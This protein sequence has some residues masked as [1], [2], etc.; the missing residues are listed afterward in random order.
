MHTPV[1]DRLSP[2]KSSPRIE[3]EEAS[4]DSD[5]LEDFIG[6]A[7]PPR[8][9]VQARG[10]GKL[11]ALSGIDRRFSD[12]YDPKL[13]IELDP[14][15]DPWD[16]A[17]EAF[18]DHQKLRQSQNERMRAAGFSDTDLAR[19]NPREK[20]V[21]DVRWKK[22]GETKEWDAGK[23]TAVDGDVDTLDNSS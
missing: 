19:F 17:V 6:P 4:E 3:T 10:R 1:R 13:D 15:G 11:S 2:P 14:D 16:E 9:P 7:P 22:A 23:V 8:S 20:T 12:T 21:D 5:P 18:R